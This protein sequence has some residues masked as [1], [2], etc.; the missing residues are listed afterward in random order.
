MSEDLQIL[1]NLKEQIDQVKRV[2]TPEFHNK[3][4]KYGIVRLVSVFKIKYDVARGFRGVMIEDVISETFESFTRVGGRKWNKE[5][6][7][8]FEKQVFSA[9]DSCLQNT[10]RKEFTK[11]KDIEP[12]AEKNEL[13]QDNSEDYDS[14]LKAS[15]TVLES[16]GASQIEK[17]IFEPYYIHKMKREDVAEYLGVEVHEIT[18]AGKRLDRKL[19]ALRYKLSQV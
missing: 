18:K 11:A 16:L 19:P 1:V 17:D 10:V 7:P 9:F 6:F 12:L 2:L 8:Q 15:L 13:E 14:M 3:M 4:M 5:K